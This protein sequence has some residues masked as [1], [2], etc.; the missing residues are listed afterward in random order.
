MFV[1]L[2]HGMEASKAI[3]YALGVLRQWSWFTSGRSDNQSLPRL[4]KP[5][6]SSM[7]ELTAW[8]DLALTGHTKYFPDES[9]L[10][11]A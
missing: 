4:S 2:A 8:T 11:R 9:T 7:V 5:A 3:L 10:P 1:T 6:N